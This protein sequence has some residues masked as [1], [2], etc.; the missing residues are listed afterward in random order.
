[1]IPGHSEKE[2]RKTPEELYAKKESREEARLKVAAQLGVSPAQFDKYFKEGRIRLCM[3]ID[4]RTPHHGIFHKNG[5]S[6]R[7][8]CYVCERKH[9]NR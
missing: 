2:E 6:W 9:R 3:G 7:K 5:K 8:L 1:V 4:E